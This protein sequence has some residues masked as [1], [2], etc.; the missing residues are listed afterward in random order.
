MCVEGGLGGGMLVRIPAMATA[1]GVSIEVM[2]WAHPWHKKSKSLI[3][4]CTA[5]GIILSV[6]PIAHFLECPLFHA[7]IYTYI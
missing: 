4:S 1:L 2:S 5:T 3:T 6:L 7:Q